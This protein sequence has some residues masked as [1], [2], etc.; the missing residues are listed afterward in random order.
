MSQ[1]RR[2]EPRFYR[3]PCIAF[4]SP[5]PIGSSPGHTAGL[6]PPADHQTL[7]LPQPVRPPTDHRR[8]RALVLRLARENPSWASAGSKANSR[9][10]PPRRHRHHPADLL[11]RAGVW[12]AGHRSVHP[13][14]VALRCLYVLFVMRSAP[15]GSI[16]SA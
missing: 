1:P 4:P 6:A 3:Y 12:A 9:T 11:A 7:D 14:T 8:I 10:R 13:H 16:S 2:N 15:A 5:T